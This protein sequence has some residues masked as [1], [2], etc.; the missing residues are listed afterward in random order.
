M[1]KQQGTI[2]YDEDTDT[3]S[4]EWKNDI[5]PVHKLDMIQDLL[6]LYEVQSKDTMEV[7]KDEN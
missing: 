5:H 4:I 7:L 3:T 1:E 2:M 6:I